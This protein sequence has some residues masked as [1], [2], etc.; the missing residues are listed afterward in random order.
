MVPVIS[1]YIREQ[2]PKCACVCVMGQTN[3]VRR[4]FK[5]ESCKEFH[6]PV[7]SGTGTH[8]FCLNIG[9]V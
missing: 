7:A 4:A 9:S 2:K 8:W 1:T 5:D 3:A 6:L